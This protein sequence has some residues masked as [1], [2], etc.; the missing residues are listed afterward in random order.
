MLDR[1][2]FWGTSSEFCSNVI[3]MIY[4][5]CSSYASRSVGESFSLSSNDHNLFQSLGTIFR[6]G[7][8]F[9]RASPISSIV[10]VIYQV[11]VS[12]STS[13][14]L[15]YED[16]FLL[17]ALN[18]Y[19]VIICSYFSWL[20]SVVSEDSSIS[21]VYSCSYFTSLIEILMSKVL[22]LPS[23]LISSTRRV[24]VPLTDIFYSATV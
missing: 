14:L 7:L 1:R 13:K 3:C 5:N 12:S 22:D 2:Y 4:F 17:I 11:F 16:G 8:K 19:Q 9:M 21:S 6:P 23:G 20:T 15:S 24:T 18:R 10:G